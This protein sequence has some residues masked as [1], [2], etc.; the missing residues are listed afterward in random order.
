MCIR[1]RRRVHGER[2][3]IIFGNVAASPDDILVEV[4]FDNT[5]R[6]I[7]V[8]NNEVSLTRVWRQNNQDVYKINTREV[9]RIEITN[10]L[11]YCGLSRINPYFII[12]QGKIQR[13][14]QMSE[15]ELYDLLQEVTGSRV[16]YEKKK[17]TM[18][19]IE[20]LKKT[21]DKIREMLKEVQTNI[22]S[23]QVEKETHERFEKTENEI[24]CIT[25]RI[26]Q[27][28]LSAHEKRLDS[29]KAMIDKLSQEFNQVKSGLQSTVDTKEEAFV[30]IQ[31]LKAEI[32]KL[33]S[34][35]IGFQSNLRKLNSRLQDLS[36]EPLP[37][38][39]EAGPTAQR[40]PEERRGIQHFKAKLGE[41]IQKIAEL[42][43]K[44][45]ELKTKLDQR[46]TEYELITLGVQ[47]QA[48]DTN[49]KSKLLTS[50]IEEKGIAVEE[51]RNNL[52]WV[53]KNFDEVQA[54]LRSDSQALENN[55]ATLLRLRESFQKD[56]QTINQLK[57]QTNENIGRLK[58]IILQLT[59]INAKKEETFRIFKRLE[60]NLELNLKDASIMASRTLIDEA[61]KRNIEGVHGL[62]IDIVNIPE[63]LV[64][65]LDLIAR[66]KLF[67][68]L[69]DNYD[70]AAS[71]IRLNQ[72][73]QGG[74]VNIYPISWVLEESPTNYNYPQSQD[75][76]I[77]K[78]K[79]TPRDKE[80][81]MNFDLLMSHF[82]GGILF[83]RNF[84]TAMKFAKDH[85][86]NCVSYDG[87]IVYAGGFLTKVGLYD[88]RSD[89]V[90]QYLEFSK[91]STEV[92][93]LQSEE[94]ELKA[95]QQNLQDKELG[96][97]REMQAASLRVKET[98]VKIDTI[99]TENEELRRR[100][101]L[102]QGQ[103]QELEMNIKSLEGG[104]KTYQEEQRYYQ[105]LLEG[106]GDLGDPSRQSSLVAEIENIR[107]EYQQ[108]TAELTLLE[109]SKIETMSIMNE[110]GAS[111]TFAAT[112]RSDFEIVD[113]QS[114]FTER[115][116]VKDEYET[117]N[118]S[119]NKFQRRKDELQKA[120]E[121]EMDL[122]GR[123]EDEEKARS[124]KLRK[125]E[126]E[127]FSLSQRR[128]EFIE[129]R[130]DYLKK[131]GKINF[132]NTT[133]FSQYERMDRRV[134]L[135]KL[136]ELRVDNRKVFTAKDK[137]LYDKLETLI[138]KVNEFNSRL[139]ELT[140]NEERLTS[141]IESYEER[142]EEITN[143]IFREFAKN[144][145]VYFK[146]MVPNGRSHVRLSHPQVGR[147]PSEE[148]SRGIDIRVLFNEKEDEDNEQT[149]HKLNRLNKLSLGQKTVIAL[150]IIFGLQKCDPAPCYI[151][152]EID[153]ALDSEYRKNL[154]KV[155]NENIIEAQYFITTF[156][157]EYL[158]LSN[159]NFL[160]VSLE[161]GRSQL[162]EASLG[163]AQEFFQ[164]YI[165]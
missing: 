14:T 96:Y 110:R 122:L 79:I 163:E 136:S 20:D 37:K 114:R 78:D 60:R 32:E 95:E 74:F 90:S 13:I 113:E 91:K 69:V 156:K 57:S 42:Q 155:L 141:V 31:T 70:T 15:E 143:N 111:A 2:Q 11:E 21:K 127:L 101:H 162:K 86:L 6:K 97:A 147:A 154:I 161:D 80:K 10:L 23:I 131:I 125:V 81:F 152:D 4:V 66:K 5:S 34:L 102:N 128:M 137:V 35:E 24:K 62:L 41:D 22:E 61:S 28:N 149:Y 123:T 164:D 7:P 144:F 64:M 99:Y 120:L 126:G 105:N 138:D 51:C 153:A 92:K 49:Q 145:D 84:V 72:E 151:F 73:L 160:K 8:D 25:L 121:S 29:L 134:L 40:R 16:F 100:T 39:K 46:T 44:L 85:K 93:A 38:P 52:D 158:E 50:K 1:D 130:D 146:K 132:V 98:K 150:C 68:I 165:N 142:N 17:E 59:Q 135:N 76:I 36:L 45:D 82:F 58:D 140:M 12:Q 55:E 133:N 94:S 67:S 139:E 112:S 27:E 157:E 33:R 107:R 104:L 124:D 47:A 118:V 148:R 3:N 116:L 103:A 30:R 115:E 53:R 56:N 65:C 9:T 88:K 83:V 48:G 63:Q 87:E 106:R 119:F 109:R 108:K 71:L 117:E 77:V 75:A 54:T 43:R 159:A 89:K 18:K 26:Y 19:V 129:L